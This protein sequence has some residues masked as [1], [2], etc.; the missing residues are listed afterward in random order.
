[1]LLD[2]SSLKSILNKMVDMGSDG[3]SKPSAMY[4]KIVAKGT[5]KIEQLLKVVIRSHEPPEVIVDTYR[6]MYN[7]DQNIANFQKILEL[8]VCVSLLSFQ[9]PDAL[10]NITSRG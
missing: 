4:Q 6:M 10:T 2:A 8:K 9:Y 1:M 5:G 7:N 3:S